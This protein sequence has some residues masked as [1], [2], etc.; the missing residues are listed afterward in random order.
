MGVRTRTKIT[1]LKSG[2]TIEANSLANAGFET[3]EPTML[4]PTKVAEQLTFWPRLPEGAAIKAFETA[5]GVT[6]LYHIPDAV[7]VQ[8]LTEDKFSEPVKC[9]LVISEIEREVLL[10]DM[11]IEELGIVIEGAGSGL[12]KFRG[13]ER[14]RESAKPQYW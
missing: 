14:V 8:A 11:A 1:S 3:E 13:E 5:G 7:E 12:W 2:R 6:R 10:S 9:A 4:V